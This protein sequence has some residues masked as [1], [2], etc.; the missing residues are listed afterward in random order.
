MKRIISVLLT[1]SMLSVFA[2]CSKNPKT[3]EEI[4]AGTS[5]VVENNGA[6]NETAE[7]KESAQPEAEKPAA[8]PT[9]TEK[10]AENTQKPTEKPAENNPT[11]TPTEK[12]VE[13]TP[14]PKPTEKPAETPKTV[15][16]ALL[17]DFQAKAGGMGTEALAN[18]LLSNSVIKFNGITAPVEEGFL[19]GFNNN[20]ITGFKEATMFAPMIGS[21]AF[22]GYIFEL[23]N[24]AD[25][26]SFIAN[27]RT[28]ADPAWNICVKAE[29]MITGSVGNKVFFVMC[30]KNFE[31]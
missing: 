10:P 7:P 12:P 21:I 5:A 22:V 19:Q 8:S 14:T 20:E 4:A 6:E 16:T 24:S 17:A 18:A 3:E 23:H 30:P 9:P 28:K 13:N 25:T 1:L 29:E 26:S 27:L 2:A 11:P 31:D 15:G